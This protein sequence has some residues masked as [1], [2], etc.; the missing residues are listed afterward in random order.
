[1]H[2]YPTI[3]ILVKY[4]Q[5]TNQIYSNSMHVRSLGVRNGGISVNKD[6]ITRILCMYY[7]E[8]LSP[9]NVDF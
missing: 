8:K 3:L 4:K 7:T 1:M 2:Q 5:S 6:T 9:S